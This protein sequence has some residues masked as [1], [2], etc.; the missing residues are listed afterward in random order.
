MKKILFFEKNEF[1]GATR[2]TRTLAKAAKQ[3][4]E[5]AF[6]RVGEN[7]K[8]D[9]ESAIERE[10]PDILFSSF[11]SIN[12]DVIEVGKDEYLT[13]VIRQ[14]YKLD[15]VEPGAK[16]RIMKTYPKAD[17]VIAQTPELKQELLQSVTSIE[18]KRIKVIEN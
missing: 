7:A 8:E 6:A 10:K 18:S 5:V 16:T 15:D 3:K 1:T 9:I 14:D 17:W 4:Y 12:P 2:V 13:V 11:T